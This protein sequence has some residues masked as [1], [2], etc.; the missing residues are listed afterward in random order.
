MHYTA[1]DISREIAEAARDIRSAKERSRSA[2]AAKSS[3]LVGSVWLRCYVNVSIIDI[4]T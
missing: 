2:M 4:N 3:G 1:V